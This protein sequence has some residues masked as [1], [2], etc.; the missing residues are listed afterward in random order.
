M[1]PYGDFYQVSYIWVCVGSH[2]FTVKHSTCLGHKPNNPNQFKLG[3]KLF[4]REKLI[5]NAVSYLF[6]CEKT[7]YTDTDFRIY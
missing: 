5:L 1:L 2:I 6:P 7:I 3:S 4:M